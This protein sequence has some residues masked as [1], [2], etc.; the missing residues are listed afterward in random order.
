M[1]IPATG[2]GGAAGWSPDTGA[3]P[4]GSD[5]TLVALPE[6]V[7][8]ASMLL[9]LLGLAALMGAAWLMESKT[10]ADD[11]LDNEEIDELESDDTEFDD[12]DDD[13]LDDDD[14]EEED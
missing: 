1:I 6:G 11:E 8:G 3:D 13:D 12:Y 9:P 2:A 7:A 4:V 5:E 14:D 10:V